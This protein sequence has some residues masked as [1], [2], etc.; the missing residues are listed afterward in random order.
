ML[1]QQL[2]ELREFEA[3]LVVV[4]NVLEKVISTQK[5]LVQLGAKVSSELSELVRRFHER[6]L[7]VK[8]RVTARY[9]AIDKA[10][11]KYDPENLGVA[12]ESVCLFVGG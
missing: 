4:G 10:M 9:S 11:V 12:S 6:W 8:K 5:K 3:G 7:E 2:E 1:T